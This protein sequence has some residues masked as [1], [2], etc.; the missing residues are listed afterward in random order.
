MYVRDSGL[1]LPRDT[2][3]RFACYKVAIVRS[4][5]CRFVIAGFACAKFAIAGFA[6]SD[7]AI[8]VKTYKLPVGSVLVSAAQISSSPMSTG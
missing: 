7:I 8:V 2:P 4:A 6:C 3:V 5:G 1:G